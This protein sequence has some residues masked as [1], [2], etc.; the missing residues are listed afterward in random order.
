[1]QCG[2]QSFYE[3]R[4]NN[5]FL[6]KK[7]FQ[8][9]FLRRAKRN[10]RKSG[11]LSTE[12]V[13]IVCVDGKNSLI[14][15]KILKD[16]IKPIPGKKIIAV[17][18]SNGGFSEVFTLF[19]SENDFDF[20]IVG[21]TDSELDKLNSYNSHLIWRQICKNKAKE[22]A[23]ANGISMFCSST[24]MD[25]V[26]A[27]TFASLCFGELKS[28]VDRKSTV[29][30]LKMFLGLGS[31]ELNL[32]AELCGIPDYE[33][34]AGDNFFVEIVLDIEGEHP[35]S[36]NQMMHSINFLENAYPGLENYFSESALKSGF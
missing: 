13:F 10:V 31:D 15:L 14:A 25:D 30:E 34:Y 33:P 2:A 8:Y 16:I 35:G 12:D 9:L 17:T 28:G 22:F 4:S 23:V 20:E 27:G 21:L 32:Y 3:L 26:L 11:I 6:C 7:H 24:C 19:C 1:M 5:N 36:K 29:T 18:V